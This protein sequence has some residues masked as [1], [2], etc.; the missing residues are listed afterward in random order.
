MQV[1]A[2]GSWRAEGL[3]WYCVCVSQDSDNG[4]TRATLTI[5]NE[6]LTTNSRYK[7]P[8]TATDSDIGQPTGISRQPTFESQQQ[9][10]TTDRYARQLKLTTFSSAL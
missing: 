2:D 4:K 1:S 10:T 3:E 8:T 5:N 6:H 9:T 7:K